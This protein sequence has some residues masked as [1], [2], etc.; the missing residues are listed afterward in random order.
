MSNLASF[1]ELMKKANEEKKLRNVA[2]K[3]RKD[4]EVIPLLSELFFDGNQR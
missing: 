1:T 3:I 2:E 4:N